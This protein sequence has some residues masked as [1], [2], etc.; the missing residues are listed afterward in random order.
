MKKNI[1]SLFALSALVAGSSFVSCYDEESVELPVVGPDPNKELVSFTSEDGQVGTR[2]GLH[3]S[4]STKIVARIKSVDN[5][6]TSGHTKGA[7]RYTRTVLL[8]G[9]ELAA[10]HDDNTLHKLLNDKHSDVSYSAPEYY[11]YWDDAYGRYAQLSVFAV[12]VPGKSAADVLSDDILAGI[13]GCSG[14]SHTVTNITDGATKVSEAN[15][16]W[17]IEPTENE[18]CKWSVPTDAQTA[19]T[20]AEKDLCYSNNIKVDGEKGVYKFKWGTSNSWEPDALTGGQMQWR[21]KE[22]GSTVGKFDQGNLIFK[23]ALCKITINLNEGKGFS[24]TNTEDFKFNG[25]SNVELLSFPYTGSLNVEA[26][27]WTIHATDG[28]GN[29]LKLEDVATQNSSLLTVTGLTL[30]D[31]VMWTD[32]DE[33]INNK[34]ALHFVIDDNDYYVTC[35]QIAQAIRTYYAPTLSDGTTTNPNK[36]DKYANFTQMKQGE[37]YVINITVGKTQIDKITAQLIG[38]EEVNTANIDPSNAYVKINL[39]ERKSTND[40]FKTY[41]DA[42]KDK[43]DIYRKE[44]VLD[45]LSTNYDSYITDYNAFADYDWVTGY[46]TDGKATKNYTNNVWATEWYWPNSLTY[47]HF[48]VAGATGDEGASGTPT[49]VK[50]E[51]DGDYYVIKGG[52]F[53]SST[54]SP[55]DYKDYIWGAPF[56]DIKTKDI[57]ADVTK[58]DPFV[59]TAENGFNQQEKD[60]EGK[61][62]K[63]QIYKAIGPTS[64]KINMMLF[65]MT[66]Q[67]FFNVQTTTDGGKVALQQ[68]IDGTTENTKV[69]ILRFY[70]NGT[71]LM[72]TGRVDATGDLTDAQQIEFKEYKP[73]TSEKGALSTSQYGVVPQLLDRYPGGDA[74]DGNEYKVGIRIT[75]PDGNQYVIQ[76]I[77]KVY[78]S[79]SDINLKNPYQVGT[80]DNANKYLINRWYPGYRYTYTITITK[81]QIKNITAQLVGWEVVNGDLGNIDLEGTVF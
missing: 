16:Y 77:S 41:V 5:E 45:A 72:G 9:G 11:R 29:I 6:T 18:S 37:H 79:V 40:N 36:N 73:E 32:D 78:A 34:N 28:Y 76:D 8:A 7:N 19:T 54:D 58:S 15:P 27:E 30:P 53:A 33:S 66:S 63:S 39:E 38:W 26:G 43:F 35:G 47:Y 13:A 55:S 10:D 70:Q 56:T 24:A 22:S 46:T 75:T 4:A 80:G 2:A 62:T 12:A 50:N 3:A 65:H 21:P 52:K 44:S 68:T 71:V 14:S 67:V 31:K 61:V 20:N 17:F 42:D 59:Y 51:D 23:H 49:V 60:S 74:T 48:R 69:E 81:T 64:D 25:S 1:Y 57:D